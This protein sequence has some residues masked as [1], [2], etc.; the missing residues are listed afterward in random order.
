MR[1]V[2]RLA[3][4]LIWSAVLALF[5]AIGW[6]TAAHATTQAATTITFGPVY[7]GHNNNSAIGAVGS[8]ASISATTNWQ[9]NQAVDVWVFAVRNRNTSTTATDCASNG[10]IQVGNTQTGGGGAVSL[11][12][13]WPLA[14]TMTQGPVYG[15]CLHTANGNQRLQTQANTGPSTFTVATDAPASLTVSP[16][17]IGVGQPVTVRGQNWLPTFND[18]PNTKLTISIGICNNGNP[19]ASTTLFANNDGT[20]AIS[21]TVPNTAKPATYQ[22]CGNNAGGTQTVNDTSNSHPPV[23]QVLSGTTVNTPM[24]TA[25]MPPNSTPTIAA[26][27]TASLAAANNPTSNTPGSSGNKGGNQGAIAALL[28]VILLTLLVGG[29]L[30]FYM[31]IARQKP[32][33]ESTWKAA[34]N[35]GN[36][37]D[38]FGSLDADHAGATNPRLPSF[39]PGLANWDATQPYN[40]N[41]YPPLPP[42]P[43]P[44]PGI[45]RPPQQDNEQGPIIWGQ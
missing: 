2:T 25:T 34:G 26:T 33:S 20:F 37:P 6:P 31:M 16:A 42:P 40:P 19:L 23:F 22:A 13:I 21:L 3:Y 24:P 38:Q 15:A 30:I 39:P 45:R 11:S 43:P 8:K 32:G 5:V 36:F 27:M 35:I 41:S 10:Y 4:L 29:G 12:F 14:A 7:A 17:T 44:P 1:Q 28:F 9:Q 18:I